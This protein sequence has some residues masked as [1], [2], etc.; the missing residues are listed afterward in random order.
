M[1]T[2]HGVAG[3]CVL[4]HLYC[5]FSFFQYHL[6][7]HKLHATAT[8]IPTYT[9]SIMLFLIVYSHWYMYSIIAL[10]YSSRHAHTALFLCTY[11]PPAYYETCFWHTQPHHVRILPHSDL[12]CGV[13]SSSGCSSD[14]EHSVDQARWV[15]HYIIYQSYNEV[16]HTIHIIKYSQFCWVIRFRGLHLHCEY[17]RWAWGVCKNQHHNR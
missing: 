2:L 7:V 4:P 12:H 9:H 15:D 16:S 8:I 17:W 13:E 3:R 6:Y 5:R 10:H 14:C 11:S 1:L